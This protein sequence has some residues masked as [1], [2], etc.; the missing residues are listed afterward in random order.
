MRPDSNPEST[1][2]LS[3]PTTISDDASQGGS[4]FLP[5]L[6]TLTCLAALTLFIKIVSEKNPAPGSET[7]QAQVIE[8]AERAPSSKDH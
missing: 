7:T 8:H 5:A 4:S 3:C 6:I 2:A 1:L